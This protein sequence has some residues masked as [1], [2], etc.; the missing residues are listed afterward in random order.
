M[1]SATSA[2]LRAI[3][4]AAGYAIRL[5]E[6]ATALERSRLHHRS[7]GVFGAT[8]E[9]FFT[10]P[11]YAETAAANIAVR[12][13]HDGGETAATVFMLDSASLGWQS[14]PVWGDDYSRRGF[15]DALAA[16]GFKGAYH[17]AQAMWQVFDP[18]RRLGVQLVGRQG[19]T[20]PWES[21]GPLR[22][23]IHWVLPPETRLCHAGTVSVDGA[24]IVLVGPG[25]S[26]KSGSTLAAIAAG[27]DTVG[28]DYCL[29]TTEDAGAIVARPVFRIL[30]QDPEG[31]RRVFAPDADHGPINWQGKWEI[32]ASRLPRQPFVDA[33]A[34]RAIVMPRVAHRS[35]CEVRPIPAPLALRAFMPSNVIQLPDGEA[36]GVRFTAGLCRRLPTFELLLSSDRDDIAATIRGLIGRL[37]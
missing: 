8:I 5:L 4:D 12:P 3:D 25:G 37:A 6:A 35:R 23:F 15:N 9:A 13:R 36:E 16:R 22:T 18:A 29:V 27:L 14:P 26:G 28:D 31:F 34:V 7:L 19:G 10:D 20:P 2:V 24:G 30:K 21:G 33:F 11:A 32:H 1:A 17:P